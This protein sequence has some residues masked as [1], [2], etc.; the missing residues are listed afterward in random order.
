MQDGTEPPGRPT[1]F[2]K[3]GSRKARLERLITLFTEHVTALD[4]AHLEHLEAILEATS[5]DP[6]HCAGAIASARPVHNPPS[7]DLVGEGLGQPI[8]IEE[9]LEALDAFASDIQSAD[10]IASELADSHV[11]AGI[12]EI[13]S[14]RIA[15]WRLEHRLIA[16]P[17]PSGGSLFPL[18]Q[19]N[20]S[21]G[22]PVPGLKDITAL[23]PNAEEAWA[24]LSRT[25]PLTA[26]SRPIVWLHAGHRAEVLR[27]AAG[28]LDFA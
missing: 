18:D 23:F 24:W 27:A 7:V 5:P 14:S 28:A 3:P 17:S 20:E 21:S 4:D 12:L 1:A 22:E 26:H 16:L 8:S 2:P 11:T 10:W 25:N 15:E 13:P 6:I 9:G 19:F